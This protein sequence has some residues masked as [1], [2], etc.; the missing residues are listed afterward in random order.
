MCVEVDDGRHRINV[1]QAD[2]L[3]FI[4]GWALFLL[5]FLALF[6]AFCWHGTIHSFVKW[7]R[8]EEEGGGWEED[9]MTDRQWGGSNGGKLTVPLSFL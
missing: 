4:F 8:Q 5:H 1:F 3:L 6:A 9:E 2:L 7:H